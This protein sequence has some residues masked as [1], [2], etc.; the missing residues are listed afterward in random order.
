MI[1][2]KR[3][4]GIIYK[5]LDESHAKESTNV[6]KTA[7]LE[8]PANSFL[9]VSGAQWDYFLSYFTGECS[10]NRLSIIA[11][12]EASGKVAGCLWNRDA[13]GELH[14]DLMKIPPPMGYT[15]E[16]LCEVERKF[17]ESNSISYGNV[18]ELWMLA[19]L[20]EFRKNG[21]SASL[22]ETSLEVARSKG[23]KKAVVETTGEFSFKS[24]SKFGFQ[25]THQVNYKEF[26]TRDGTRPWEN[27][28]SPHTHMRF[29]ELDLS[30]ERT[31]A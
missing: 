22:V 2:L 21:I 9:D 30:P 20:P 3:A 17:L 16:A 28:N 24:M 31:S 23:F 29:L 19:V 10:K 1:E 6:V 15:L 25:T 7:F 27:F 18:F 12:D 8:E 4:N 5:V 13:A 14:E 26:V 11:I